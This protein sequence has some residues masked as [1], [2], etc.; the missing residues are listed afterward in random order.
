MTS[1]DVAF[2]EDFESFGLAHNK[3]LFHDALPVRSKGTGYIDESR[4]MAQTGPPEVVQFDSEQLNDDDTQERPKIY[5]DE[6]ELIDTFELISDQDYINRSKYNLD[7]NDEDNDSLHDQQ[8]DD[9]E[10]DSSSSSQPSSPD[11]QDN[12]DDDQPMDSEPWEELPE[13]TTNLSFNPQVNQ[14]Q[15]FFD[16]EEAPPPP[17]YPKRT[18][19]TVFTNYVKEMTRTIANVFSAF[20]K[21]KASSQPDKEVVADTLSEIEIDAPGSDPSPFLQLP[22]SISDTDYMP[23]PVAKAWNKSFVKEVTGILVSRQACKIEDPNPDDYVIPVMDVYRCKLDQ[24]G[25]LDKVKVRCVFRGD[26]YNPKDPQDPW[27]PHA[28]FLSY[29]IFLADSARRGT[30]PRQLDFLNAFLQANMKERVF[31]IFPESWKKYLPEHLHKYIGR[32]LL[33]LK[34]LYGY[35]YSGKFLYQ[36]QAEF[37]KSQEFEQIMFGLWIKKM[38]NGKIIKFLHYVDDILIDSD[39]PP[40]LDQFLANLQKRFDAEIKPRA[41]WFLQT[42]VQQDRDKNITLDQTRYAKSMVQRFLPLMANQEPTRPDMRKYISPMCTNE[43]ISKEHCSSSK[44]EVKLLEDEYGFRYI[45]LIGCFN[46]L[47]YTCYEELYAT[48]KLCRY[49]NLPGRRHFQAALHLLHHFRCHP[50]KPL[51]YYHDHTKAPIYMLLENVKELHLFSKNYLVCADSSHGDADNRRSTGCDIHIY[52]GGLIDHNSWVPGPVPQSTAESELNTY[53]ASAMR[54]I[55]VEEIIRQLEGRQ[56]RN[57][58]PILVDNTAAIAM[59]NSDNISR[60]ARHIGS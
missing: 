18:R 36:D 19:K 3:I 57:T 44:E 25:L 23:T 41:D 48:R 8:S 39:D 51:I 59:T 54:A 38:P 6:V 37:L 31:V 40:A 12:Q 2:D 10:D 60:K 52:Q 46:W 30:Y 32:P 56:Y 49:M 4:Q 24:N 47:S 11:D 26:L 13:V 5:D 7:I 43:D 53:S 15:G 55:Y 45:E 27:N 35:T 14:E 16:V 1:A 50:P 34:A 22:R 42:R 58:V 21:D 28:N 20:S 9:E 33:L 29:K 17:R